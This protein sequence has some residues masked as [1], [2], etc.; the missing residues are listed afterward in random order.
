MAATCTDLVS[1]AGV[2]EVW[3]FLRTGVQKKCR[4]PVQTQDLFPDVQKTLT[5]QFCKKDPVSQIQKIF[6]CLVCQ[7]QIESVDA[8]KAHAQGEKHTRNL[9]TWTQFPHP[10]ST[11][12]ENPKLGPGTKRSHKRSLDKDENGDNAARKKSRS[13]AKRSA[14]DEDT[15][16][17]T[18][19]YIDPQNGLRKVYPYHFTFSTFAK[20]RWVGRQ[21]REIFATEFRAKSPSEYERSIQSGDITGLN[22]IHRL[23]RLTSGLLLLAKNSQKARDM[24]QQISGRHVQKEYICLVEG[25]FPPEKVLC[26]E[27]IDIISHKIGVCQVGPHGKDCET[28]F[29]LLRTMP[30]QSVVKCRPKTGRM[31]QIRVHLQ[32]LGYPIVNDPLYN[33]EAFGPLKGKGGET[34]KSTEQLIEDLITAHNAENW[35]D[36]EPNQS[37]EALEASESLS[38]HQKEPSPLQDPD[39]VSNTIQ[40]PA[41]DMIEHPKDVQEINGIQ[42]SNVARESNDTQDPNCADCKLNYRD[43]SPSELIMYLHAFKYSGD[44]WSYET[45]LPAWAHE[46]GD[47]VIEKKVL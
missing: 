26:E 46:E 10:D 39:A 15:Y 30:N 4:Q 28:E 12:Q 24:E 25:H 36:D 37:S 5:R 42:P 38:C 22:T 33:H 17:E 2:I 23:D 41:T 21:I 44:D 27:P 35:L 8:L 6:K 31:H 20:R 45:S 11:S 32:Y 9:A 1:Q 3:N 14:F 19:Y 47:Q 16:R 34:G 40:S 43:P 18:S 29:E 13:G 7:C